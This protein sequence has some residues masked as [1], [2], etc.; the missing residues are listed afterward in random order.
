[1]AATK[2]T[3]RRATE[4]GALL[5]AR[6]EALRPAD[7]GLPS[8]NR[9]RT[10]GLRREEVALLASISPTYLAILEQG[11][12]VRPSRPVLDA[13]ADALRLTPTER[14]HIHELIHGAPRP[15]EAVVEVLAPGLGEL[16]ERLD[17]D[18]AYVTG[19]RWDV[20]A[21]NRS[22]RSLWTDW[23]G[24]P[25]EERNMIWWT[26]TDPTARRIL[27]DWQ[28]E[29]TALLARLR[30]AAARNPDDPA[31]T[32]L[33]ERLQGASPEVRAWWPRHEIAPIGSGSKR[34]HHPELG[35]LQLDVTTLYSADDL[36]QK[37]V[38]FTPTAEDRARLA[39]LA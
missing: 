18:P 31:F 32:D 15:R 34:L 2:P 11:R 4:V 6:R 35:E 9:R 12:D 33:I 1:M 29:A 23:P 16:V 25:E 7:V 38:V 3:A 8:G 22:A 10:P 19:R 13:L 26:F 28:A 39:S 21:S 37:L 20:L 14:A 17:P 36:E 30:A 5:R 24:L 27:V